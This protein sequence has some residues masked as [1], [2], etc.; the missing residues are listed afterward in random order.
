MLP[1]RHTAAVTVTRSQWPHRSQLPC[2]RVIVG[3][4]STVSGLQKIIPNSG[5]ANSCIERNQVSHVCSGIESRPIPGSSA[6]FR[7]LA[8]CWCFVLLTM[9]KWCQWSTDPLTETQIADGVGENM[10]DNLVSWAFPWRV[11]KLPREKWNVCELNNFRHRPGSTWCL[12][13]MDAGC[14]LH[15]FSP[16]LALYIA[17]NNDKIYSLVPPKHVF[18]IFFYQFLFQILYHK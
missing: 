1:V 8:G 7:C 13:G 11:W 5:G 9:A 4:T 18:N 12:T 17:E 3:G 6:F 16:Y 10:Q 14:S 2:I 15:S